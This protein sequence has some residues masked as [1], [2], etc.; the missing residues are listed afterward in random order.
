MQMVMGGLVTL[1]CASITRNIQRLAAT[2]RGKAAAIYIM[3]GA[4]SLYRRTV[5]L[6]PPMQRRGF[7][8]VIMSV[9]GSAAMKSR[10]SVVMYAGSA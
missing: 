9:T 2:T 5:W 4:I 7:W 1:D 10:R 6:H 8:T 3:T